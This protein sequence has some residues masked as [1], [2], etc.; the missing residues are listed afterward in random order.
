MPRKRVRSKSR[1]IRTSS[2]RWLPHLA[3]AYKGHQPVSLVDDAGAGINPAK[4]TLF[5]MGRK[6]ELTSKEALAV[7]VAVGMGALGA[8][9]IVLAFLDPEPTSKLAILLAGGAVLIGTGGFAAIQILVDLKP[10]TVKRKKDGS[11]EISWD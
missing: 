5:E 4:D 2:S 11:F 7:A 3:K 1:I 10:P 9:M 6:A 8:G